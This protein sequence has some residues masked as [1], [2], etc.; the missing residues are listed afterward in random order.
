[1]VLIAGTKSGWHEITALIGKGGM[2]EVDRARDLVQQFF[3]C[4]GEHEQPDH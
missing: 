4:V 1:M 2:G 3:S